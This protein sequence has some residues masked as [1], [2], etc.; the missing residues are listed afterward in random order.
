ML[1]KGGERPYGTCGTIAH[2]HNTSPTHRNGCCPS[3]D[4]RIT[5]ICKCPPTNPVDEGGKQEI[6]GGLEDDVGHVLDAHAAALQHCEPALHEEHE[7]AGQQQPDGVQVRVG[8][9]HCLA[10]AGE[11][12]V[13]RVGDTKFIHLGV[14]I[15]N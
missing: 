13:P 10:H 2:V 3:R 14:K 15:Y 9:P 5:A 7:D 12:C 4:L 1:K 6:N 11:S 8:L